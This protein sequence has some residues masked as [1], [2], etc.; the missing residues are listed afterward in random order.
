MSKLQVSNSE[1]IVAVF[2]CKKNSL[3]YGNLYVLNSPVTLYSVAGVS[4]ARFI[5]HDF[6]DQVSVCRIK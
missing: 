1:C 6:I 2:S 3:S 5:F 4:C